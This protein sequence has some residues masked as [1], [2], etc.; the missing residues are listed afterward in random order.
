MAELYARSD[1]LVIPSHHEGYCV[2]VIEAY[3]FG[4]FV[5]SYDA[6]NLPTIVGG[7]GT[8]VPTGDVAALEAAIRRFAGQLGRVGDGPPVLPAD[9]RPMPMSEWAEAVR[10]HL[11]DYSSANFER[12]F[13]GL[14]DQLS[15]LCARA[16]FPE[17]SR[18]VTDRLGNLA[19]V[20]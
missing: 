13:L 12:R 18:I 15:A 17:V 10:W 14:F 20:E 11:R 16:P 5:V 4:R 2:P 7:L 19:E 3:G 1:V 6:G 9:A 8:V